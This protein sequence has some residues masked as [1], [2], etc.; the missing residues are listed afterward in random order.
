[1]DKLTMAHEWA[2]N[3]FDAAFENEEERARLAWQ[4]ADAMKAEAD[5][6]ED[7]SRPDVLKPLNSM[8]LEFQPDWSVAPSWAECWTK[9]TGGNYLWLANAPVALEDY[10]SSNG[11]AQ[12]APSFNYTGDWRDSLRKRP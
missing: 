10:F 11:K 7:K 4:Y 8:E 9:T 12:Q 5:K 3:S 6:R 1:M 2:M